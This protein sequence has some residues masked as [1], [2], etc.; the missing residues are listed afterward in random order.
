MNFNAGSK[1]TTGGQPQRKRLIFDSDTEEDEPGGPLSNPVSEAEQDDIEGDDLP[2]GLE[3]L[4]KFKIPKNNKVVWNSEQLSNLKKNMPGLE[5]FDDSILSNASLRDLALMSRQQSGSSG[6][7]VHKVFSKTMS[8]NFE[9]IS[10]FP[11]KV[12][13]G[14][15]H[16]S[17]TVHEARFLRGYVG[18]SQNLWQQARAK[19]GLDGL[20]P[21]SNYETVSVGLNG[22]IS[23]KAWAEIHCPGSRLLTIRLFTPSAVQSVWNTADRADISKEFE[24]LQDLKVG[25]GALE[26]AVHKVYPWNFSVKTLSLFLLSINFGESELSGK[27]NRLVFTADF[28]DEVLKTNAQAWDEGKPFTSHENLSAKWSAQLLRMKSRGGGG[29]GGGGGKTNGGK[30]SVKGKKV[31]CSY[32]KGGGG[33]Q[34]K[35]G[36]VHGGRERIPLGLCKFYNEGTCKYKEKSHPSPWDNDFLL[37]HECSKNLPEK[38]RP[39]FG[40]HPA[41]EHK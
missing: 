41:V 13:A 8:A 9:R 22:L 14:E 31:E 38:K 39:C 30:N 37:R 26:G 10:K 21:I 29:G 32:S 7:G 20:D 34:A 1:P 2:V 3:W 6:G 35:G 5:N 23:A 19:L 17:G 12:E 4:K 40:P 11:I 27:A 15:D 18:D 25:L 16:C 33:G 28:I 36:T 24:N